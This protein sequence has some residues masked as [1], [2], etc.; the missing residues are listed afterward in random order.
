MCSPYEISIEHR[1]IPKCEIIR[2]LEGSY[3]SIVCQNPL[4]YT[5]ATTIEVSPNRG[6][7]ECEDQSYMLALFSLVVGGF[8]GVFLCW[9]FH[10]ISASCSK[11]HNELQNYKEYKKAKKELVHVESPEEADEK[12]LI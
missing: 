10:R 2:S 5:P 6:K 3:S 8:I 11:A 4:Q 9:M 12:S 1:G 7:F